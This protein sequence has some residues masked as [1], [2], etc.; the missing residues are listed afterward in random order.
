[1]LV[2]GALVGRH[3]LLSGSLKSEPA[4]RFLAKLEISVDVDGLLDPITLKNTM[5]QLILFILRLTTTYK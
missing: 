2:L 3:F 5:K 1:L 4:D